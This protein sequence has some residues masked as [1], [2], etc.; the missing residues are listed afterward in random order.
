MKNNSGKERILFSGM[1]YRYYLG[2]YFAEYEWHP[3]YDVRLTSPTDDEALTLPKVLSEAGQ[4]GFNL[5]LY[6]IRG[7][8]IPKFSENY[9]FC[10]LKVFV[11][12]AQELAL[13]ARNRDCPALSK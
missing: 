4:G 12:Q 13:F 5:V 3:T 1:D 7:K 2:F 10:L 9:G 8:N 11:N 6:Q